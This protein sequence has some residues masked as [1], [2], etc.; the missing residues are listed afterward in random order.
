MWESKSV[1]ATHSN[2]SN[3]Q[4]RYMK[5]SFPESLTF[6]EDTQ[7]ISVQIENMFQIVVIAQVKLK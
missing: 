3:S 7:K 5:Q 4:K 6:L 1:K 2:P